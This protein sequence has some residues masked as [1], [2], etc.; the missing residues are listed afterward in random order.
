LGAARSLVRRGTVLVIDYCTPTTAELAARPWR[1]WL[2]TYRGHDRGGHYLEAPG[3]QDVTTEVAIDQLPEPD[4]VRS[5]AQWLQLHG[6]DELVAEGKASWQQ[7]AARPDLAAMKMRSRVSEAEA[8]L[9][10]TGLGGFTV[11][12]WRS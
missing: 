7:H 6:I 12:E 4:T 1:D 2:R 8:L 11:L 10:P 3:S 9:D 5:Q